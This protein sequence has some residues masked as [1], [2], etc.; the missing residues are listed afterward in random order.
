MRSMRPALA[1]IGLTAML[2][3]G[4]MYADT[5]TLTPIKDNTLYEPITK[6]NLEDR[7]NGQHTNMFCGRTKDAENA[8]GE[9]AVRRAVLAFDI[10]GNIYAVSSSSETLRAYAP[11]GDSLT[12]TTS[13]GVFMRV[14]LGDLDDDGEIGLSD[15]ATLL[16]NYGMTSGAVYLD[17][18]L[19]FDGDV[20]L[21]DLATLLAVYGTSCP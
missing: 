3:P 20:D 14:C 6:D 15:L 5:A 21:G 13:D 4:A 16:A 12:L 1:I 19:D 7:S 10:A 11:G 17:G 2:A 18:D 9:V 8:S